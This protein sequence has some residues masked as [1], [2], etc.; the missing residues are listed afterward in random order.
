MDRAL[1]ADSVD[2]G[3]KSDEI[4]HDLRD[5][6]I[7]GLNDNDLEDFV[8]NMDQMVRDVERHDE[9]NNGE[10]ANSSNLCRIPRGPF[11]LT[12]RRSTHGYLG[13]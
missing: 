13:T 6:N 11:I 12:V 10:F 4:D 5:E 2:Q 9:Y 7:L 1:H 8:E 3:L